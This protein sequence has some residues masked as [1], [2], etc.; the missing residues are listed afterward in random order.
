MATG[1][2]PA[3][4][5]NCGNSEKYSSSAFGFSP[6]VPAP[7]SMTRKGEEPASSS[8]AV[9]TAGCLSTPQ[10]SHTR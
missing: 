6:L 10:P 8:E 3:G 7:L 9:R 4:S 2:P 5:M 1:Q